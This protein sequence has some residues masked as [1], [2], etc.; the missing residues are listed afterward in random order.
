MKNISKLLVASVLTLAFAG[1]VLAQSGGAPETL[2]LAERNVY[3]FVDGKMVRM[4][5]SDPTHA[6]IMKEFKPMKAGTMIYYSGG[7]YYMADDKKMGSGKMLHHEIYGREI[8]A[9]GG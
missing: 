8:G 2:T 9:A 5:T 1:P 4:A 7:R 6:M 3:L